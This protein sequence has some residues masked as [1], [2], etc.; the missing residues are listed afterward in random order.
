MGGLTQGKLCSRKPSCLPHARQVKGIGVKPKALDCVQPCCRSPHP[1]T[2]DC[3]ALCRDEVAKLFW[4]HHLTSEYRHRRSRLRTLQSGSRAARS[5]RT[6]RVSI[7][8]IFFGSSPISYPNAHAPCGPWPC[9]WMDIQRYK[10]EAR[11]QYDIYG[12]A[13][14]Q[15]AQRPRPRPRGALFPHH[16]PVSPAS[17]HA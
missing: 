7:R 16:A 11:T 13:I 2:R 3:C 9:L 15:N 12:Q 17:I 4:T 14:C 10:S 8:D 6:L 1:A 5:P